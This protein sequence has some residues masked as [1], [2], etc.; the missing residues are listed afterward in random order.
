MREFLKMFTPK[1]TITNKILQN[2][3]AIE[4]A[5][6]VVDYLV[7][8]PEWEAKFKEDA[9]IRACYHGTHLETNELSINQVEKIVKEDPGRD[10]KA[11]SVAK[12]IE[13]VAKEK[14]IQ[15]VINYRNA[16]RFID[17][18]TRLTRKAGVDTIGEKEFLQLH[19]LAMEKILASHLLGTYRT[20]N[21]A[22]EDEKAGRSP[23]PVEVPY[24]MDD[25]WYWLKRIG[26][27]EIHPIIS[28]GIAQFELM[29]IQPFS[30]GNGK[31]V[32]LF[33]QLLLG[34]HGYN[35]KL[36]NNFDEFFD[37]NKQVYLNNLNE[38]AEKRGELTTWI[39]FVTEAYASEMVKIK[40]RS[41][42]LSLEG[43]VKIKQ[44]GRQIALTERQ[45]AIMEFLEM[46]EEMSMTQARR[47]LPM[48]SDDTILRDLTSLVRKKLV[49][50]KGRTKGA[51]YS[52]IS[53]K[54]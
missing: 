40:E 5:K 11:E 54:L 41:R 42:R 33:A 51:R 15:E 18:L 3:S 1:F 34:I 7:V 25:F 38:A 48:V 19:S 21:R 20:G 16:L 13:I 32:R 10:E 44:S 36:W 39:E 17:Q 37:E 28:I 14:D 49:R 46:N 53:K 45:I 29:R 52:L 24:Q 50:K 47:V 9:L 2:I 4:I 22:E 6:E 27:T 8:A 35:N 23:L 31:S 30:S 12:K 43:G 26:A